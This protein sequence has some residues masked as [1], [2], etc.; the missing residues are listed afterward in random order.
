MSHPLFR[1]SVAD[2][3]AIL[4]DCRFAGGIAASGQS[5]GFGG[6][7]FTR[8]TC[9]VLRDVIGIPG[10]QSMAREMLTILPQWQGVKHDPATNEFP[11]ALSHQ[12]FREY[13]GGRQLTA[14]QVAT[15][16]YWTDKWGVPMVN[17]PVNG[18]QFV[19]YNSSDAPLLYLISLYEYC[20]AY[21]DTSILKD[22]FRHQPTTS[23][24]TV[25][26]A[27]IRCATYITNR[28]QSNQANGEVGGLYAVPNTNPQQTSPSGV[29]RD[30]FDAYIK[31]NGTAVDY[32]M[33]A[34]L[35]NQALAYE[36]LLAA[37]QLFPDHPQQSTW[38][39]LAGELRQLTIDLLWHDGFFAA[40]YDADGPVNMPSSAAFEL[41]NGPFL[42]DL[43]DGPDYVRQLVNRLYQPDFMTA[44]GVRMISLDYA[45][46]EGD[47]YAYQ[48]SGAVWGVTTGII[49]NGLR[50]HGLSRHAYDLGVRRLIDWFRTAKTTAELSYVNRQTGQPLYRHQESNESHAICPAELGQ[51]RQ[52]WSASAALRILSVNRPLLQPGSWQAAFSTQHC[53]QWPHVPVVSDIAALTV[54]LQRGQQLKQQRA[55]RLG[56]AA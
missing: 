53:D 16:R 19:I 55:D 31:P 27:A 23:T 26:E 22:Q 47:Y 35:D 10:Y 51:P 43:P 44:I 4:H 24:R 52:A 54:N 11:D 38:H 45:H 42:Q 20:Q 15:A 6:N 39:H 25:A 37:S 50:K 5:A 32:S 13:T 9:R 12:V 3:A 40:A 48:G 33:V 49:E 28:L 56:I 7:L 21:G 30:G 41:L 8:D 17:H 46:H 29:M 1:C 14:Q 18:W 2:V 34:Y 36:A